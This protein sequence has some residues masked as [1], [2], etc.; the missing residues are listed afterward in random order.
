MGEISESLFDSMKIL[1]DQAA[2]T[3]QSVKILNCKIIDLVDSSIGLYNIEYLDQKLTAYS[4]NISVKY[5]P[6]D[7]V[8]V[9][10]KDG[11]LSETLIII[12][13]VTPYTGLY[14]SP[15]SE[16]EYIKTADSIFTKVNDGN[17]IQFCTHQG[18]QEK[19]VELTLGEKFY[20]V[21]KSYIDDYGLFC[22]SAKFKTDIKDLYQRVN[23][24]YGLV[25][26]IPL[27]KVNEN[28][29]TEYINKDFNLNVKEFL[30][31][32]YNLQEYTEQKIYI[33]FKEDATGYSY[34]TTK[35]PS[36][37]AYCKDFK[38]NS[39]ITESDI[40]IDEIQF[41]PVDTVETEDLSGYYL[42][43]TATQGNYFM[44]NRFPN[45]KV[46]TPTLFVSGSKVSSEGLDHYWFVE[47]VS[48]TPTSE[49]YNSRGGIG[50]RCL[51]SYSSQE[52]ID[53]TVSQLLDLTQNTLEVEKSSVKTSLNYKCVILYD[54]VAI[55]KV[56]TLTNLDSKTE[57]SLVT[58]DSSNII[59][60]NSVVELDCKVTLK[61]NEAIG[62]NEVFKYIL[63]RF[64]KNGNRIIDDNFYQIKELN[65]FEQIDESTHQYT[66]TFVF[67]AS[68]MEGNPNTFSCTVFLQNGKEEIL[69]GN[70]RIALAVYNGSNYYLS[71]LNADK[72][73]KYDADGDSPRSADYDG[74]IES[75]VSSIEPISFSIYKSDGSELTD[76]EYKYCKVKYSLPKNTM[77]KYDLDI[78]RND[79]SFTIAEDDTYYYISR[80]GRFDISYDIINSFNH[81]KLDN[82]IKLEVNIDNKNI[83]NGNATIQFLKEG[84]SGTNGTKFSA[85][86]KYN[87]FE[88]G[89]TNEFGIPSKLQLVYVGDEKAWYIKNINSNLAED[90]VPF[91]QRGIT[92]DYN[93]P[94]LQV[95][96]YE[97]GSLITDATRYTILEWSMF[98]EQATKPYFRMD[99]NGILQLNTDVRVKEKYDE[100]GNLITPKQLMWEW[101]DAEEVRIAVIQA[102]VQVTNSS[103][104]NFN[105]NMYVHYPIELTRVETLEN[106][107]LIPTIN[108]GFSSV[109]YATDGSNPRY[110]NSS[111]VFSNGNYSQEPQDYSIKEWYGSDNIEINK[112]KENDNICNARPKSKYDNGNAN[113]YIKIK[114]ATDQPEDIKEGA[115]EQSEKYSFLLEETKV[116]KKDLEDIQSSLITISKV[117]K[118]N[119]ITSLS[120]DNLNI[121]TIRENGLNILKNVAEARLY[122][123]YKYFIDMQYAFNG[124]FLGFDYE[125]IYRKNSNYISIAFDKLYSIIGNVQ[126][127]DLVPLAL[128]SAE[129]NNESALIYLDSNIKNNIKGILEDNKLADANGALNTLDTII[130]QYNQTINDYYSIFCILTKQENGEYIY[131]S[132]LDNVQKFYNAIKDII[133]VRSEIDY[134]SDKTAL[135]VL[136][137][138]EPNKYAAWA[139]F[140]DTLYARFYNSNDNINTLGHFK[141]NII[142]PFFENLKICYSITPS[143]SG[144]YV[145]FDD[146]GDVVFSLNVITSVVDKIKEIEK[147][148]PKL[149]ANKIASGNIYNAIEKGVTL[150]HVKP[151]VYKLNTYE[152]SYLNDW[153]GNKLYL[154]ENEDYL[155]APM[156]GA[157]R[158]NDDNTFTGLT[159]GIKKFGKDNDKYQIGLFGYS[160]GQQSIFLDAETG[161]AVFG[162]SGAGQINLDPATNRAL[163]FSGNYFETDD[164][165][166]IDYSKTTGKGMLIDLT[167]PEIRFG[168]EGFV[169]D[170]NGRLH[171]GGTGEQIDSEMAGWY[172]GEYEF[173]SQNGRLH[174]VSAD[175]ARKEEENG[176]FYSN[177]H[178]NLDSTENGFYLG[179]DGFSLGQSIKIEQDKI[180]VGKLGG[181]QWIISSN[182]DAD[183]AYIGYNT[184]TILTKENVSDSNRKKSVYLGT[185]G[186]SIGTRFMVDEAGNL[187]LG[188]IDR[189]H[190]E[191]ISGNGNTRIAY[192]CLSLLK[193]EGKDSE[194]RPIYNNPDKSIYIGTDGIS[195]GRKFKVTNSGV[196]EV[197][198][199][200]KDHWKIDSTSAGASYIGHGTDHILEYKNIGTE[201]NP[202][203]DY[204]VSEKDVYFGTNG[205]SIGHMFKIDKASKTMELGDI[206]KEH[207][208][209]KTSSE[210]NTFLA[211]DTEEIL[212]TVENDETGEIET[213][214]GDN[215]VYIGTNGMSV[216]KIYKLDRNKKTLELGDITKEHWMIK[217]NEYGNS[218]LAYDKSS[219]YGL[220]AVNR[221]EECSQ[222]SV[223]L[224]TDGIR[225]G[226]FMLAKYRASESDN[227]IDTNDYIEKGSLYLGDLDNDYHWTITNGSYEVE[228]EPDAD[229]E[230]TDPDAEPIVKGKSSI[231]YNC[232]ALLTKHKNET[233]GEYECTNPA[234]SVYIGTNGISIGHKFKVNDKGT[235][236]IGDITKEHWTINTGETGK[237]YIGYNAKGVNKYNNND[238]TYKNT[239]DSA[240]I[241][242]DG[243]SIGQFFV[244]DRGSKTLKLGNIGENHWT[245]KSSDRNSYISYN[246]KK[247]EDFDEEFSVYVGTNGISLGRNFSVDSKGKLI[248]KEAEINGKI[249]S[250]EGNI[251]GWE[252]T[253]N[254]LKSDGSE[255]IY[256]KDNNINIKA[257]YSIAL[258][259]GIYGGL[260]I[261][262]NR[263]S[264]HGDMSRIISFVG[265]GATDY[266]ATPGF[267]IA[268]TGGDLFFRSFQQAVIN[269]DW[270]KS[271]ETDAMGNRSLYLPNPGIIGVY[272]ED[273]ARWLNTTNENKEPLERYLQSTTRYWSE[274]GRDE[275]KD[276]YKNDGKPNKNN[277]VSLYQYIR[278]II[279]LELGDGKLINQKISELEQ[280][281]NNT[282]TQSYYTKSYINNN[283]ATQSWVRNNFV[284]K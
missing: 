86:L 218:F 4:N 143:T 6:N 269:L 140:F 164:E 191:V 28:G 141:N 252:I 122:D 155:L 246:A 260:L 192:D 48:V 279:S 280:K 36:L 125:D 5:S 158:K 96:V 209:L 99:T 77:L 126:L 179:T 113:N 41:F 198:D 78:F 227:P 208:T 263:G 204:T 79:D 13:S 162:I 197:G 151:I 163:L 54:G 181:K 183:A 142:N 245:I 203:I 225:I 124:S 228:P 34:D 145:E 97:N 165:G 82:T 55:S 186:I 139:S 169:V 62:N 61:D 22:F 234:E 283:Y 9:I 27:V 182:T 18:T 202:N 180:S 248:C 224:G 136:I 262:V 153:D 176:Y 265:A 2:K 193:N 267:S 272:S 244:V 196:V 21:L 137:A 46:L 184:N 135:E 161:K 15:N 241:G 39:D 47:D 147:E 102:K 37:L 264:Q 26:S 101:Y 69:Y 67:P 128:P 237:T 118:N 10:S 19:S 190:W 166:N 76:I 95:N 74:P 221:L 116:K 59:T 119:P 29:V 266:I 177:K 49:Y 31:D 217:T 58:K 216:G 159:M 63:Q 94:T 112:D 105:Q 108:E 171:V 32:P 239:E 200:G 205:M 189:N 148:Y 50:W 98:D 73:Y 219:F 109:L 235:M 278:Y 35:Q 175:P 210:Y 170:A 256:D 214:N 231:T 172:I 251:A 152:S 68:V 51:N 93:N 167:T 30:G 92:N 242:T 168:S 157:G 71:I 85:I 212:K 44:Q 275:I 115:K 16:T 156:M 40:F 88:Y 25:L 270:H 229:A 132:D 80:Q 87:N 146:N 70:D 133:N 66:T 107:I 90:L 120:V 20:S 255:I 12:G 1:Y 188:E 150:I 111:F 14:T 187:Y 211:Y 103:K 91:P 276:W 75:A 129:T 130:N 274:T 178:N 17:V 220:G 261:D 38:V 257:D 23:G 11:T 247:F 232:D 83:V 259:S 106:L 72:L 110:N 207:W 281:I 174:L 56:I 53:G 154:N 43:L 173:Y 258:Q 223:Y 42:S 64:D 249:T 222:K 144:D 233:T 213:N 8:Y 81:K 194:G 268:A 243:I 7:E 3:Q 230:V 117:L 284:S 127:L 121:M 134:Y 104:E 271:K 215:A 282:L 250:Q 226:H 52:S 149:E 160:K 114:V 195:L 201:D 33:N 65:N 238:K 45:K 131:Q 240:Y 89:V 236:E 24:D 253:S 138:L 57:I 206:G 273:A 123:F 60:A 254:A 277:T 84:E 199:I 185:N 100:G